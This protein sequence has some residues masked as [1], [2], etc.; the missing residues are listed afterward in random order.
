[1]KQLV[2]STLCAALFLVLAVPCFAGIHYKAVTKTQDAAAKNGE[3]QVE[4]WVSGDNAKV[5]FVE[6]SGNP[7]TQEGTFLITKDGGRT[8]YL[9]NPKEKTYAEW[10]LQGMLGM[11]GGIMSGMGPLLKVQF[12]EPKVEKIL[13]ED[14]GTVAGLPTRHVKLRTS[15]TMTVKVFGMGNTTDVV[16]EQDIWATT[17]LQDPALGVWLRAE[18]PRTGNAEFDKLIAAE[19]GKFQGFPLKMV[20]V[21]TSTQKK[22]NKTTTTRST[23]E[24]TQIDTSASVPASA[25]E[26]PA[27]YEKVELLPVAREGR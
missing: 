4:G 14:G 8:L 26:I 19:A 27:G 13:E 2:R 17:K 11:V 12:S 23:M 6:S 9:V 15:Y 20:T 25:F 21:S 1:V 18:P 22:G 10:D 7:M 16:S 5:A 24:V 3:I